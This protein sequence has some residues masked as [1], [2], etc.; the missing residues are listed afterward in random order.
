MADGCGAGKGCAKPADC[1]DPEEECEVRTCSGSRCGKVIVPEGP[2][3]PPQ[4][5]LVGDCQVRVCDGAGGEPC[6]GEAGQCDAN[7]TCQ[8]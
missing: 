6:A 5:Q 1:R 8:T 2:L 3:L 4:S 7:G